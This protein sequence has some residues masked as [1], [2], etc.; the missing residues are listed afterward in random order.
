M[1]QKKH[2]KQQKTKKVVKG[3]HIMTIPELRRAF[4]HVEAFV[5]IHAS[6]PKQELIQAFQKEWRLTFKKEVDEE[7][8]KAYVE[9]ALAEIPKKHPRHRRHHGGAV[10]LAGAPLLGNETRPGLY[11]S[12]GVDQGSYAQVPAYVDKG[13]W[14][15]EQARDYDPVAG[16]THYVTRTPMGMGSNQAGGSRNKTKKR[17]Q[18]GA[19][20][21]SVL[22]QTLFNPF[23]GGDVPSSPLK[24]A[25]SYVN[26]TG[27][28][29][30][31][32]ASQRN[33][34]YRTV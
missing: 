33:P 29:P 9:H 4:E 1:S 15:S 5:E 32:D 11:I 22:Q 18:K 13:F 16:Q 20:L 6:M 27:M 23:M 24:D 12:P 2:R 7:G 14:N 3:K 21:L 34:P 10:P 28:P 26:A 25:G 31:P 8:A 17:S 19:G 30:S